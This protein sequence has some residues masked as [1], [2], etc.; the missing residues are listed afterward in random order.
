MF[1]NPKDA[2]FAVAMAVLLLGLVRV[3]EEYPRPSCPSVIILAAGFGLSIGS[4]IMGGFGVIYLWAGL[5]LIAAAETRMHGARVAGERLAALA[6]RILIAAVFAY[7]LMAL[8]WPWGV[9]DPFNPI[10]AIGVF[11]HFFEKPWQELFE[12][13]L[14]TPPQM[15][16]R[17]VPELLALKLPVI[18]W[19]FGLIGVVVAVVTVFQ[20]DQSAGRRA[21]LLVVALAAILPI[22]VAVL[23]RPAMYNGVRHFLFILP[24]LAV[25][26]GVGADWLYRRAARSMARG[27]VVAML[28][29]GI[30]N[31]IVQMIR[32]HPYQ[33]VHFNLLAGSASGARDRFMLDYWALSLKQAAEALRGHLA[34]RGETPPAGRKWKVAVCGPHPAVQVALG[35]AFEPTWEPNGADF[36]LMLGEFYCARLNAPQIA[37]I[38]RAGVTFARVHD[39]R[40]REVPALFTIPPVERD[41]PALPTR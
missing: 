8:V 37:A 26:A 19:F 7:A 1:M 27:A 32:L 24:P 33:Y 4:R 14:L 18:F 2:P 12:G 10:R 28:V 40:G 5:A 41:S 22:A 11:S 35:D 6:P 13:M 29:I 3:F 38:E 30:A 34:A 23:T 39:I 20:Q 31:S 25:A 21:A 16:R 36:A 9:I 15:P 17:Y